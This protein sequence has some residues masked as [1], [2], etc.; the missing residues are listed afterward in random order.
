[1][2]IGFTGTREGL[3]ANQAVALEYFLR[4]FKPV[5]EFHHGCCLGADAE[6]HDIAFRFNISIHAHP[7]KNPSLRMDYQ[8]YRSVVLICPKT[9]Y[10]ERNR[11]IVDSTEILIACPKEDKEPPSNRG[12]PGGTWYTIRYARKQK[13]TIYIL[14]P[15]AEVVQREELTWVDVERF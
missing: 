3:S 1:M 8:D 5:I 10:L 12:R 7:A 14:Y 6:A 11:N 9:T 13:H 4:K 2:K 15:L